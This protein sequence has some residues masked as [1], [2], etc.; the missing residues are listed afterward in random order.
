MVDRA[1]RAE[2]EDIAETNGWSYDFAR[3][4]FLA[5]TGILQSVGG[6][7]ITEDTIDPGIAIR[8]RAA[9]SS[10]NRFVSSI[11]AE[12]AGGL[13]NVSQG[14]ARLGRFAGDPA[15]RFTQNRASA[16]DSSS[17]MMAGE[18]ASRAAASNYNG[19]RSFT[20]TMAA[21]YAGDD[22]WNAA[23]RMVRDVG[24]IMG[25]SEEL[26]NRFEQTRGE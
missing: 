9:R 19:V 13:Y 20:E 16:L 2:I 24:P 18:D 10:D 22:D 14:F 23:N 7:V 25:S 1:Y 5:T 3:Q 17:R 6:T 21:L 15:T 8:A 11:N 4:N 12:V 26:A